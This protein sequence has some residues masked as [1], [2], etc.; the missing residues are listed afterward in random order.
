M[1][2]F[3]ELKGMLLDPPYFRLFFAAVAAFLIAW[4]SIPSIISTSRQKGLLYD[5]ND[6]SSHTGSVPALGGIAIFAAIGIASLLFIHFST[7]K[8]MQYVLAGIIIVFLIGIKDDVS[9]LSAWIKLGG[10]I[11]ACLAV[12]LPGNLVLT[13]LHGFLTVG[14]IGPEF[15]TLLTL[16]VMIVIINSFNLIDGIDGL[17]GGISILV[18]I[19]Y[20]AWF[21]LSGNYEVAIISAAGA[22]ALAAF[23][24]FNVFGRGNKIFMGDGGALV[25]GFIIAFFTILFNELNKDPQIPWHVYSAPSVSMGILV[26]PLYDTI[27]VFVMR[28]LKGQSPF[29]PDRSHVH[30]ILIDIGLT[31]RR[32]AVVLILFNAFCIGL[33]FALSAMHISVIKMLTILLVLC[34]ASGEILHQVMLRNKRKNQKN[35]EAV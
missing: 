24:Y 9:G 34:F 4:F 5:A 35:E 10:Q 11:I 7:V 15:G 23:L 6:R 20:G 27:R 14:D 26:I 1:N 28:A 33:A 32:A 2:N 8:G 16:F 18:F 29:T 13:S 17:A 21:Y 22:S 31:H 12:I 30:H 3:W 25:L 19:T